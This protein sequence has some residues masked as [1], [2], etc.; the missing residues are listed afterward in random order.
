MATKIQVRRGTAAQWTAANPILSQGEVGF[1]TDTGKFKIG[2]GGTTHW[3]TLKY[4]LDS[5]GIDGAIAASALGTTDDLS[6]G[7]VNKYFT[8]ERVSAALNSG[9]LQNISFTYNSG[10]QTIDVSVPT[11]QGTTGPQGIQGRQGT[12]GTQGLTGIQGFTGLQGTQ[13]TVGAQGIQG[14]QGLKGNQGTDGYVGSDGAQGTQGIQGLKGNP[15]TD[16]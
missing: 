2:V 15:G 12:T 11:V 10:A 16:G 13:G 1:E 8:Y 3:G 9:A 6:E 5:D 7:A 14:V 4:F